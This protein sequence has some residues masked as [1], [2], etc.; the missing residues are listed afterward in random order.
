MSIEKTEFE[1]PDEEGTKN[2][3]AGGRVVE[4]ESDK[5]SDTEIEIVDDTPEKDRHRTPLGEAPK[6]VT[7]DELAKYSDQKL[8]DRLAHMNK[9]YHE[10]RRA[11]EVALRER[12]EAVR[13]AQ[14]VVEENKRLQGSL[15]S[16]QTALIDQAK[17]V[18]ASEIEDA[19]RAY[20]DAYEAG[21]SEA[22]TKA[23]EKLTT[24]SIRA[25]K[26]HNFK[27]TPLQTKEY[28]VQTQ[29]QAPQAPEVDSKT[30]DWLDKNSWFG[31]NRKMAAYALILHEDL[32]DSGVPVASDEYYEAIDADM[33]KRFPESF[34]D[35]P[36]DAK[37]SQRTKSNVVA[38]ASRSTAPRK[39][40]LTQTQVNIAKRLGVP[41]ELYAR[42]VAEEMRK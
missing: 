31:T 7:D 2:A 13:V 30:R 19:K 32:K 21:D 14:S 40:V 36:A 20:K 18:V 38:P 28:P 10:E 16:N 3:R 23:Q 24:A 37:T 42:K 15:A 41:L 5:E 35:E 6:P 22:L 12:E 26:V 34:A 4:P 8:K 29:Q 25:D 11:K 1:F 27:P 17:M 39:I 9:G 33:R